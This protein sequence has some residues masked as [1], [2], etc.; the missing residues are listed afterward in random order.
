[1]K[2]SKR[3]TP[4][5]V[6]PI[7]TPS[8][9][10]G[11]VLLSLFALLLGGIQL[12][13]GWNGPT[14]FWIPAA[15]TL[16]FWAWS[17][18]GLLAWWRRPSNGTGALL[19]FGAVA[20]FL[21]GIGNLGLPV[22]TEVSTISATLILAV[23]VHLLHAFPSGQ[24]RGRLSV[25]TVIA[26]YVVCLILQVPNYLLPP[27]EARVL[28]A[29]QAS[30]GLAV[31]L[32]T[33]ALLVDRLRSADPK[34]L[35]VLLPLYLYGILAVLIIPFASNVLPLFGAD[36]VAVGAVQLVAMAGIPLAFLVG[37]LAG[38]F[39]RTA[40]AD[41]LSTWLSL[42]GST[43]SAVAQALAGALGDDSLRVVYWSEERETFIDSRGAPAESPTAQSPRVRHDVHVESRLAG[44][45]EYDSRMIA[46][47]GSVERAGRVLAV[48]LDRERLTAALVAS[49]EALGLSRMRLVEAA[50]RE[51]S[52]IARDLHD[53]LQVQFVLLALEAQQIANA[54][55]TPF[56]T[57]RAATALRTRIDQ[58][59]AELRHLVHAVLPA[60][61]IE[62]GLFAAAEDLVDRLDI[63]ARL[64]GDI[65]DRELDQQ[66]AQTAYLV[67]AEALT[68]AV[69]HSGAS[70]VIV[71]LNS[72]DEYLTV[73]IE[74]DGRGGA[75]VD[76]GTGLKGLRDRVEAFGGTFVVSS[77]LD[78]GTRL[79]V[80]LPCAS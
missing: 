80:E 27:A 75:S 4:T 17:S 6:R 37:V 57:A 2:P 58:A 32:V 53:G 23:T 65:D 24:L 20:M 25:T 56:V 59:A 11:L 43:R 69:K 5:L 33:A 46:D 39:A 26:G 14:E 50:D 41:A 49:N 78:K 30:A 70:V 9:A 10:A 13:V 15:F 22:L 36:S 28:L 76:A 38:G 52:R 45:I 77:E 31:F 40:E 51:R 3:P 66:T 21:A 42:P 8:R 64:E 29:A 54:D 7:R 12:S 47:P 73:V 68:N 35:R 34:N 44:A 48:A 61:L 16:E 19:L 72:E 62:R 18:T 79:R 74:D 67:V 63:P 60:A 55:T 1:M 71:S